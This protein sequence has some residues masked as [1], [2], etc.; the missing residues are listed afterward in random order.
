M[1]SQSWKATEMKEIEDM[2]NCF[3]EIIH[4]VSI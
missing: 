3:S 1:I 4:T 2:L